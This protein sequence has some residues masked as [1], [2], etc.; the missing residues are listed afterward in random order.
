M[1]EILAK[2]RAEMLKKGWDLYLLPRTD[3][4]QSEYLCE[5]DER[6]CY[7]S[8]F[9]GSNGIALFSQT[10]A[11]VW[12][13]GRYFLQAEKEL[14]P[15][16]QMRKLIAGEKTWFE[17]VVANY[18]KGSK[19][20]VDPRLLTAGKSV[21]IQ[22]AASSEANFCKKKVSLLIYLSITWLI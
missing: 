13:D 5:T 4:H 20:G 3:E 1:S 14:Y 22:P 11:L 18:A 19:L 6:L 15:G 7:L 9:S 8:G 10:E 17:H 21:N 12:T 2:A 16:W